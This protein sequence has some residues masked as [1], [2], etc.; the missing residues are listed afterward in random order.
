MSR[1]ADYR[2]PIVADL[3]VTTATCLIVAGLVLPRFAAAQPTD[4]LERLSGFWAVSFGRSGEGRRLIDELPD[5]VVLIEDTGG[6]ELAAGEFGGLR[7]T[8][9]ALEEVRHYDYAAELEPENACVAPSAAFYMQ[10]PFPM[11][12]YAGRDLIVFRMEYFDQYRVVFLDGRAHPPSDAPH[13]RSGHSVG[14]WEGD[15][16]VVDTTHMTAGTFMNNGFQHTDNLHMVERF[17]LSAEGSRLTA[18]QVY[19]DPGTFAG[20]AARYLE[21]VKRPGEYVYPYDCD[22]GYADVSGAAR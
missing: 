1:P 18:T 21:W 19:T 10:A 17:R 14:H 16:L 4:Y 15:T 8:D 5:D 9:R 3:A 12:I 2:R 22:P 13:S 7:L 20:R 6:G 11:E